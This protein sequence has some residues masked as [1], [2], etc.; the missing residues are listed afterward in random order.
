[1]LADS[2]DESTRT[3]PSNVGLTISTLSDSVQRVASV[4]SQLEATISQDPS[5]VKHSREL[6][7]A[8]H[9][10]GIFPPLM[11]S[12]IVKQ[13]DKAKVEV[14][15]DHSPERSQ[16]RLSIYPYRVPYL[17]REIFDVDADIQNKTMYL[18][19]ETGANAKVL[20]IGGAQHGTL[21]KCF[22]RKIAAA[23]RLSPKF[24]N[25]VRCGQIVTKCVSLDIQEGPDFSCFISLGLDSQSLSN[26][27]DEM[28]PSTHR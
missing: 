3:A 6:P 14:I 27:I 13:E 23:L 21:E 18:R 8:A 4:N 12:S 28:W 15:Q 1:M 20:E 7:F 5:A 25:E 19:L 26:I 17:A 22:G 10:S 11:L 24:E 2:P 9:L 16:L